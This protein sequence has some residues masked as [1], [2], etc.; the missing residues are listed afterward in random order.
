MGGW[1]RTRRKWH[2][3]SR[4]THAKITENSLT[5]YPKAHSKEVTHT[6]IDRGTEVTVFIHCFISEKSKSV[7]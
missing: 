3:S 4:H 6:H 7:S 2:E 5:T 1:G